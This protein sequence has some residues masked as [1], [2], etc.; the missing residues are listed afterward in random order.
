[1]LPLNITLNHIRFSEVVEELNDNLYVDDWLPGANSIAEACVKFMEVGT[2]MDEAGMSLS[3]WNSNCKILKD[4]FNDKFMHYG[5]EETVK[6][7]GMQWVSTHDSFSF[8]GVNVGSQ[9]ELVCTKRTVLSLIARCFD[10]LGFISPIIMCTKIL[11]QDVWK[12]GL[13]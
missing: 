6:V 4:K 13:G 1:M 11:F 9:F 5:E 7:L 8:D 12:L 3:K 10:P 2:I